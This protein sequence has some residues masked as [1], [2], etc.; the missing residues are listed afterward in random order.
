MM[1]GAPQRFGPSEAGVGTAPGVARIALV[2]CH[3]LVGLGLG[4][5]LD[6]AGIGT[7]VAD[8]DI[9]TLRQGDPARSADVV[10]VDASRLSAVLVAV[11]VVA[12]AFPTA[13]IVV[14]L[15]RAQ[16][17]AALEALAADARGCVAADAPVDEIVQSIRTALNG[18]TFISPGIAHALARRLRMLAVRGQT[19]PELTQREREVL[20]LVALGRE[21]AEIARALHLS[22]ATIKHHLSTLFAKLDVDNRIQAAVRAVRDGLVEA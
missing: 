22:P 19:P 18:E 16:E 15:E 2:G 8:L 3:A 11:G 21:N 7:I 5:L 12:A 20:A 13:P 9:G 14:L 1:Y 6:E 17:R 10:V 4:G